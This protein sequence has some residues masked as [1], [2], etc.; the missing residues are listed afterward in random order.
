MN[1]VKLKDIVMP[2]EFKMADFFNSKLKG[3]YAYWIQMRYI[4][5]LESLNYSSY[6]KY[7]QADPIDFLSDNTPD[8]IDLYSEEYCMIDFVNV[9]VDLCATEEANNAYEFIASNAY[10]TDADIDINRLRGFRTWLAAELLKLDYGLYNEHLGKY[11][12]EVIHMLEFYKNGMYNDVVKYLNIF[13]GVTVN[14]TGRNISNCG[15]G[16]N[17]NVSSLYNIDT[18][19]VCDPK[20]IYISNI[21]DMMVKTFEEPSFWI[22]T[23][24]DFV[25]VFKKYIDNI[26]KAGFI[27]NIPTDKSTKFVE[28]DCNNIVSTNKSNSILNKLSIALGYIIDE[29]TVGNINFI[30]DALYN[31]AEY[32]YDYME[33]KIDT[34]R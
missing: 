26:I 13:G 32:L 21:H 30:H 10:A 14:S 16:C 17:N 27:V 18:I 1:I 31:W 15:C 8:H 29:N 22:K 6:I 20:A 12:N 24:I 28:C 3:R 23:N 2:N 11:S 25:K 7:E 19:S 34:K 4:F 33:W 5:P 9:F